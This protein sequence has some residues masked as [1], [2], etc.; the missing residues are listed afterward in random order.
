MENNVEL[1]WIALSTHSTQCE[2]N[3]QR[4]TTR[5]SKSSFCIFL[6]GRVC[7]GMLVMDIRASVGIQPFFF[8]L[9]LLFYCSCCRSHHRNNLPHRIVHTF[10]SFSSFRQPSNTRKLNL[11]MVFAIVLYRLLNDTRHRLLSTRR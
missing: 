8:F 3:A 9:L 6:Y 10:F 1:H 5:F 2:H 11:I 4:H 7:Q